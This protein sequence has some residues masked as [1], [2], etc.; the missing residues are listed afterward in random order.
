MIAA[1]PSLLS[2]AQVQEVIAELNHF[3]PHIDCLLHLIH[4]RGDLD[5]KLTL[6]TLGKTD[7]FT[8]EIDQCV[9]DGTCQ[10]AVHSA[11]DLPDPLPNELKCV[12]MTRGLDPSDVL[13]LREG[14]ELANG[15]CIAT[16]S[17][18]REAR[19]KELREGLTFVDIRGTVEKRLEKLFRKEVDGVVVAMAAL[20]R[21]K[22]THLNIVPLPGE[23][24]S[25]Q[26]RLAIVA[27]KDDPEMEKLFAVLNA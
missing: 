7:F 9:I 27:R 15:S 3:H 14:E 25:L 20:I 11:K 8:R 22:L 24:T 26:G 2:Q 5:Q 10:V 17:E 21:L 4:S 13:V 18:R 12:A 23:T 1:R 16:S 6:R 19:V